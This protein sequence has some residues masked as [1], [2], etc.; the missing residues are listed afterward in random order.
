[1]GMRVL[2][3]L[4]ICFVSLV[5]IGLAGESQQVQVGVAKVDITPDYPTR[6]CGYASRRTESEGVAQR[7]SAK[8]LAIDGDTGEGPAMLLSV[9]SCGVPPT[10]VNAMCERLK[11]SGLKRERLVVSVTHTHSA[12][13]LMDYAPLLF[14]EPL[15]ESER[16]HLERYQRE[17]VD[18]LV[19]VALQALK[20]RVPA[21][22]FWT[23]GEAK[24]TANRRVLKDGRWAGFGEQ[25]DGPVDNRLPVL[26][27]KC[28]E[29]KPI[30]IW[31]N[32]ACHC[33]TL[34]GNFNRICGDWAGYAQEFIEA[35]FPGATALISIGC[36][37]D[38]N[39]T[40]RGE[41]EHCQQNGRAFADEVRRLLGSELKPIDPDVACR[42]VY[43]DLPLD[44]LPSREY[45]EKTAAVGGH[46]GVHAKRFL[47]RIERGESVP[48]T[49][50]YPIATWTF[51]DDLAM[52]FLGGEV[53]VDF[54]I[55]LY[56]EL[57]ADRL[58]VTAYANEIPCYISSMRILD[59]GGYEA[60]SSMLYY[61]QPTR[62]AAEAEDVLIDEAH[63]LLNKR[64]GTRRGTE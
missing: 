37:A 25:A 16:Q 46:R 36:G 51:G 20:N 32:Y 13:W 48:S 54:A 60:D 62:L 26:V 28:P 42:L 57:D 41:L 52:V 23:Q 56:A 38:A 63:K 24:F 15:P 29:G 21:R 10:V 64:F 12:P 6:L 31:A 49:V 45:W 33:T 50:N 47:D 58:W 39:P 3:L 22:L 5:G 11:P 44:E 55:R 43:V 27:A 61:A 2:S 14:H 53:V 17:L 4:V 30:A 34:G 7:L 9:E 19:N 35:E 8:A 59:E 40:P 1:M 18:K